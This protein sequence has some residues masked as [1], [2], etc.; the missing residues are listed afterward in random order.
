M[1]TVQT[2]IFRGKRKIPRRERKGK[3]KEEGDD[4]G[5]LSHLF[6]LKP[7]ITPFLAQTSAKQALKARMGSGRLFIVMTSAIGVILTFAMEA[8]LLSPSGDLGIGLV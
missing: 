4:K 1:Y 6:L 2:T 3:K 8:R 7:R 5:D